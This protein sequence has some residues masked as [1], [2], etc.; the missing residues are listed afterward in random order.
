MNTTI[1]VDVFLL[2]GEDSGA[3]C[4][5]AEAAEGPTSADGSDPRLR[6]RLLD[7]QGTDAFSLVSSLL[8]THELRPLPQHQGSLQASLGPEDLRSPALCLLSGALESRSPLLRCLAA[9]G[10]A[11]L[12]QVVRDPG[13][14]V[15]AS[16]LCFDRWVRGDVF[17]ACVGFDLHMTT[18]TVCDYQS[19]RTNVIDP[20]WKQLQDS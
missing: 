10:L 12:V 16:L 14:T 11:R 13:F 6:N 7:A 8:Q 1:N 18:F 3:V 2:Q 19:T 4:R 5:N 15:S 9:D 17:L 20:Q